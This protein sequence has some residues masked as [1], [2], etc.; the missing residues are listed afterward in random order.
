ML[1]DKS[2]YSK[3]T[4]IKFDPNAINN[5]NMFLMDVDKSSAI[6]EKKD[7][8]RIVMLF[9]NAKN[10]K[11]AMDIYKENFSEYKPEMTIIEENSKLKLIHKSNRLIVTYKSKAEFMCFDF[12]K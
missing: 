12:E 4:Y 11:S 6:Q 5:Y 9:K 3:S 2:P 8:K 1:K 7:L 10:F